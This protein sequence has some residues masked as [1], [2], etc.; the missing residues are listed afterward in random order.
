MSERR[1]N[2]TIAHEAGHM[3]LH[4]RLFALQRRAGTRPLIKDGLDEKKQTILCRA[5]TV[6]SMSEPMGTRRYDGKWWEFQANMVIGALLLPRQLVHDALDAFL[7][8]KG[9][10][11]LRLLDNTKREE[12]IRCL[13]EAFDVNGAVA[14]IRTEKLFPISSNRQLTL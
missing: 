9:P 5:D 12:A 3:L 11:G 14:R 2:S 8:S 4:G 10:F 7:V 6:G 13:S 1:L